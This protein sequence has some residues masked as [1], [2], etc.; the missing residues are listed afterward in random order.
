MKKIFATALLISIFASGAFAQ[1][2]FSGSVYAGIQ[3]EVNDGDDV[4]RPHHREE[5]VPK[6]EFTATVLRDNFGARLDTTFTDTANPL[7]L[8]GIYGWVNFMD[9]SLR[10]TMGR[11]SSPK[12][13]TNLHADLPTHRLDEITGFRID[14][15]TPIQG[16]SVGIAFETTGSEGDYDLETFSE[17]MIIGGTFIHPMFSAVFAYDFGSNGQTIFGF[18][19]TGIP[20]LTAGIQLRA[21]N[22]ASWNNQSMF[23]GEL[24]MH[25][26]VGYRIARPLF[27]YLIY[28]QRI[29]RRDTANN[30]SDMGFEWEITPGVEYRF[31]PDLTGIFT[32]TL[33]N[34]RQ[35]PNNNLTIRTGI[36][37]LLRG[38]AVFYAEYE[39]RLDNMETVRHTISFG[40][41]VRT[42]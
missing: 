30:S 4:I 39:V 22:L 25:Q 19:F 32:V 40:L 1:L 14:Y 16:L 34:F 17:Q 23:Y 21:N 5:G 42:F 8:N 26:L 36:E 29:T 12:W 10:L 3:I 15:W 13:A 31:L 20:D 35:N 28:G 18:N 7:T 24:V 41:T 33:D 38:P 2:T 9:D 6:F 37:Y 11:M 27:V